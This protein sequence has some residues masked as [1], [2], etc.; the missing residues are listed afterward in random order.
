MRAKQFLLS[1]IHLKSISARLVL[2]ML[3]TVVG[4]VGL[5]E[6]V[7]MYDSVSVKFLSCFCGK[8]CC[9]SFARACIKHAGVTSSSHPFRPFYSDFLSDRINPAPVFLCIDQF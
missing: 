2:L 6:N 5:L 1:L 4:L 9:K 3:V 7:Y 8:L